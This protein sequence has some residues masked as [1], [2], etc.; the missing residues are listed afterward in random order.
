VNES[1]RSALCQAALKSYP[2]LVDELIN[3]GADVNMTDHSRKSPLVYATFCKTS[4]IIANKLISAGAS[5]DTIEHSN[6]AVPTCC[7]QDMPET[8]LTLLSADLPWEGVD[9]YGRTALHYA[10]GYKRTRLVEALLARGADVDVRDNAGWLPRDGISPD[11]AGWLP[12][13]GIPPHLS[14]P[15]LKLRNCTMM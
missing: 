14:P 3:V 13:D 1:G 11:K 9:A 10:Y 6:G 2:R 7:S 5:L 12:R 8:A 4:D 15:R